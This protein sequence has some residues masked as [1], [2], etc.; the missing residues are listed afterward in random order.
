VDQL[1]AEKVPNLAQLSKQSYVKAIQTALGVLVGIVVLAL[2]IASLLPRRE[3]AGKEPAGD[4][5]AN[6]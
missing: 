3:E 5:S 1:V 4:A 2:V 6:G